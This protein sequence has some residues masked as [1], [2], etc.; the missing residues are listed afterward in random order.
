MRSSRATGSTGRA[1][2]IRLSFTGEAMAGPMLAADG[3]TKARAAILAA[4]AG[5]R[6]LEGFE[7]DPLF[8]GGDADAGVADLN[9]DHRLVSA[10][11][12]MVRTPALRRGPH[13]HL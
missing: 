12:G 9:G 4:G 5:I 8:L 7:D 3:Q 2:E 1:L 10:Q 11:D 6:L 13:V